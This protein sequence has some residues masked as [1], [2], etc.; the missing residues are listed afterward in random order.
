[1]GEGWT[2][3]DHIMGGTTAGIILAAT[4]VAMKFWDVKRGRNGNGS[5]V[6]VTAVC[7]EVVR[8][9]KDSLA[10]MHAHIETH[11][12]EEMN[13]FRQLLTLMTEQTAS[14]RVVSS[15]LEAID[16]RTLEAEIRAK[17]EKEKT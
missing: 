16:R 15:K 2:L 12:K 5:N 1:M 10:K 17:I 9:V 4:L 13:V 7:K 6:N 3:V 8:E 11:E 14:W